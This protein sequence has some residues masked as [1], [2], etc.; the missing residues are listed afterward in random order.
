MEPHTGLRAQQ[1]SVLKSLSHSPSGLPPHSCTL[2]QISKYIFEKTNQPTNKC[3]AANPGQKAGSCYHH[4]QD[5]PSWSLV[6]CSVLPS[7][8]LPAST[9]SQEGA[10]E[11]RGMD[12]GLEARDDKRKQGTD[13]HEPSS[14]MP[15]GT[16][17][18]GWAH[19]H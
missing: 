2:S 10:M 19:Q 1:G 16:D 17:D 8:S 4:N 9:T 13:E 3:E 18:S 5:S 12:G 15:D 14:W 11:S 7:V 6:P